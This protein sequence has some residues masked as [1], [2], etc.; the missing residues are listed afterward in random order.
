M[1]VGI[2]ISV[3]L[4]IG[5]VG[6][7]VYVSKYIFRRLGAI[8]ISLVVVIGLLHFFVLPV[9][10][11]WNYGKMAKTAIVSGDFLD[12][13]P[14]KKTFRV[15]DKDY[16]LVVDASD[17]VMLAGNVSLDNPKKVGAFL[18]VVSSGLSIVGDSADAYQ[19]WDGESMNGLFSESYGKTLTEMRKSN[20]SLISGKVKAWVKDD[21]LYI[22]RDRKELK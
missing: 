15:T 20:K 22:T 9:S 4:I 16:E 3:L 21:R 7:L 6:V 5:L 10:D 8:F 2:W 1:V 19:S 14:F 18:D 12:V 17:G 13:D 11:M